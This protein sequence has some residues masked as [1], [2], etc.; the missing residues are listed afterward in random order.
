MR[1]AGLPAAS[2]LMPDEGT[3]PGASADQHGW[4]YP[5]Q[6]TPGSARWAADQEALPA[7]RG[8]AGST[9]DGVNPASVA[10]ANIIGRLVRAQSARSPWPA[11]GALVCSMKQVQKR[12]VP[13]CGRPESLS[14]A[15]PRES[16]Q[17]EGHP[18]L[19][20]SGHPALRVRVR[21]PRV[22]RQ[23]ILR[24]ANASTSVCSPLRAL[25]YARPP[26]DRGPVDRPSWPH[27]PQ[28]EAPRFN[29]ARS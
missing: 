6:S 16:N 13:S 19:A 8:K 18:G 12:F 2:R 24:W 5:L 20:P 28:D 1:C 3:G 27:S 10:K 7:W 9:R 17:R 15:C 23:R 26:P 4:E 29:E 22:R 11:N 14:L 25:L 21:A